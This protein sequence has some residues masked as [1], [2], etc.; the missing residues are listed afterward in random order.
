MSYLRTMYL[1]IPHPEDCDH[2]VNQGKVYIILSDETIGYVKKREG[3]KRPWLAVMEYLTMEEIKPPKFKDL[4]EVSQ[5]L[6]QN[7]KEI[8]NYEEKTAKSIC[9][10]CKGAKKVPRRDGKEFILCYT[11]NGE[12][13]IGP[14]RKTH[15]E[16]NR[17]PITELSPLEAG[18]WRYG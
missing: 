2:P 3:K 1:E 9:V 14:M 7:W 15:R 8:V 13:I 11:C 18:T 6:T 12:G 17:L 10:N 5:W 16:L 4:E